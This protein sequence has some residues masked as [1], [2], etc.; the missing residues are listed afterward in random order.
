MATGKGE[1]ERFCG[2]ETS[3]IIVDGYTAT[4]LPGDEVTIRKIHNFIR[5]KQHI[6]TMQNVIN[7]YNSRILDNTSE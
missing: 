2:R 4:T 1:S 7:Q 6:L 3:I 5:K